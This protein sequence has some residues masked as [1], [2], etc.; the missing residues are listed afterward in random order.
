MNKPLPLLG[1]KIGILILRPLK[2][3]LGAERGILGWQ[4]LSFLAAAEPSAL[5]L[6]AEDM[7]QI[8]EALSSASF[9]VR[10]VCAFKPSYFIPFRDTGCEQSYICIRLSMSRP[11][12]VSTR[13]A[14]VR[15]L[16]SV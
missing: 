8:S 3:T 4:M 2:V 12:D 1:I 16:V 9:L 6:L 11:F 15:T 7:Q 5:P 10:H 14:L 13:T